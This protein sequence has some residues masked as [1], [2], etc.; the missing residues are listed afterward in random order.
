MNF[1][2]LSLFFISTNALAGGPID[3]AIFSDSGHS[4][5]QVIGNASDISVESTAD[6]SAG[7]LLKMN[8]NQQ[9]EVFDFAITGNEA[10]LSDVTI[11]ELQNQMKQHSSKL[12]VHQFAKKIVIEA[13]LKEQ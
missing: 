10:V 3:D 7:V 2:K 12:S 6:S 8:V 13:L 4:T 9:T 1:L 11:E 5:A